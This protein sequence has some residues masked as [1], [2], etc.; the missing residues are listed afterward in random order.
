MDQSSSN[1]ITESKN[2]N[3]VTFSRQTEMPNQIAAVSQ[4]EIPHMDADLYK[5]LYRG[6][7]VSSKGTAQSERR[8]S[9][10]LHLAAREGHRA[11]VEALLDAKALHLEIE[12]GVG[13]DKAMLRMTNKGKDTALH[14]AV[15]YH[16]S[17]V[18]KFLIE[19][20]PHFIYGANSIGYTPLYMAAE[21]GYGDL[22]KI[23][24]NTSPS[25][26]H[27]GIEGR[28]VLHAAVLCRHQAMTKKIL[29]WKP[30]LI[31]EVDENGWSPLHCAAYIRD[32]A[33]TKQLLDGSSQDK[34]VDENGNNVFHFAMMKKHASRFGSELLIKDGLRVRGLVNEKDAQGDT[35][36]HLLAS[37]G[38]NDVEFI[39]DKTVDKMERNKRK[40][41][42]S[43]NFISSR[44]KF[45]W[46]TVAFAAG[47]TWPGG[48]SD[49]DGMAIL[50]KK[51]SFKH[52]L[53][54]IP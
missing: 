34:S 36:L 19:A 12:S 29:E 31:K 46:G 42:F 7:S 48:Y 28:T 37:F 15:R 4:T 44:N 20:D 26:D 16:H 10:P 45:S 40:L 39:L 13:T 9:T 23:I 38:V 52:L 2:L 8:H 30:M 17:K 14:E 3:S 11:V 35:P 49:T 54:R 43:D 24:I 27:K 51:A 32:A 50:T 18:V 47:F 33:I 21:K 53:C 5:T 1:Q 6:E 22:V 41:N 25:S